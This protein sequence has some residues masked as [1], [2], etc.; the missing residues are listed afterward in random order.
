MKTLYNILVGGFVFVGISA[1]FEVFFG[2]QYTV[3]DFISNFII[4]VIIWLILDRINQKR[5]IKK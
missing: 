2:D 5:S 4:G 1:G 3:K